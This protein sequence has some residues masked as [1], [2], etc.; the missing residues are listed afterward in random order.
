MIFQWRE[1]GANYPRR[2]SKESPRP[3]RL[4][5]EAVPAWAHPESRAYLSG[6]KLTQQEVEF[7]DLHYCDG[8]PWKRRVII[9]M[10]DRAGVLTAFQ[11]RHIDK[12]MKLRYKTEG[13]RPFY[14]PWNRFDI[15]GQDLLIVEGPFDLYS[16]A[17]VVKS[18]GAILGNQ[19]SQ[20]QVDEMIKVVQEFQFRRAM[21]W[22]DRGVVSE[23]W[24]LRLVLAPHVETFVIDCDAAKDPGEMTP[25]EVAHVLAKEVLDRR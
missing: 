18:T 23:A 7:F 2:T 9:P 15:R 6:R 24:A 8:G 14:W 5:E 1:S 22:F 3:E 12:Q 16:A 13:P 4:P 11:G 21:I 17:R 20:K 10:Y 25:S 19:P